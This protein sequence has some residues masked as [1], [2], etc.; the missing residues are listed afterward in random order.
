M[1]CIPRETPLKKTKFS[2]AS[3]CSFVLFCFETGSHY[4]A[5][6][7]LELR[8]LSLRPQYRHDMYVLSYLVSLPFTIIKAKHRKARLSLS[9]H[10]EIL[11][12]NPR[13]QV[14]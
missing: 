2:F 9:G 7:G 1:V 13:V 10:D 3:R 5:L 4:V 6:A 14:K 8:V 11:K 12:Q